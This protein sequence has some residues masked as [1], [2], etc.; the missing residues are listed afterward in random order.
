[1]NRVSFR[2]GV[3]A[4]VAA[5][6]ALFLSTAGIAGAAQPPGKDG[7]IHACFKAKGKDKGSLRVVPTARRCRKLRGWRPVSWDVDGSAGQ[8]GSQGG[9]GTPGEQGSTG[10]AGQEGT[11]STVEKTL[12][13][14]IK[15][16]SLRI[17]ELTDQ[18]TDLGGEL[19]NL[20]TDVGDLGGGL[21]DLED[22]VTG[23]DG[24]LATVQDTVGETCSQLETLT[25]Q[26]D[27]I[28]EGV[29]GVDLNSALELINGLVSFPELP[30]TL[31]S[32]EC[33]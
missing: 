2:I 25:E 31:G 23:L 13:E 26:S 19:L 14:T 5:L 28:V 1:M 32:F 22:D 24:Q 21:V 8:N 30:G 20:Q 17:D 9:A 29:N 27:E 4:A 7:V 18:V 15:T 11:A 6:S 12:T 10:S 3:V 16:Q 33:E